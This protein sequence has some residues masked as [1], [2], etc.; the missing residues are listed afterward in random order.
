[1]TNEDVFNLVTEAEYDKLFGM[2]TSDV[3]RFFG[4][5]LDA[6]ED[7]RRDR[8]GICALLALGEVEIQCTEALKHYMGKLSVEAVIAM[9]AS[10][11]EG[12]WEKNWKH[13][14]EKIAL[15]TADGKRP[16]IGSNG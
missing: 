3:T 15:L 10:V 13:L 7:D 4:L 16:A 9:T 8:M 12:V 14:G 2:S 5:P 1:M 11:A 6:S